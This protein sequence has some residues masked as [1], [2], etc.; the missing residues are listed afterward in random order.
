MSGE[1]CPL[2]GGSMEELEG[3]D[4]TQC[5]TC[6]FIIRSDGTKDY[7]ELYETEEVLI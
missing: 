7:S 6:G 1:I 3:S 4:G 5:F 2:C